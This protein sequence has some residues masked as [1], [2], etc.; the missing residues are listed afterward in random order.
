MRKV[1]L[2]IVLMSV[3]VLL[4]MFS[5]AT[6]TPGPEGPSFSL[7]QKQP[8]IADDLELLSIDVPHS[9]NLSA[10]V[11]YWA[12]IEFVVRSKIEIGK[13]CFNFSGDGQNCVDIGVKDV[14]YGS[15]SYFRVP[16]HV[17]ADSKRIDCYLE[18][19]REGT[20]RRTN[21]VSYLIIVLKKPE[22]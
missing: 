4:V 14:I 10:N 17:P 19:I 9:G 8:P 6:I 18:Y 13:A 2:S 12:N 7:G 22:E 20:A 1:V 16:I 15:H 3:P 5:C 21:T 11:E